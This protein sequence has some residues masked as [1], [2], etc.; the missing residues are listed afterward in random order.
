[1]KIAWSSDPSMLEILLFSHTW[2]KASLQDG[3]PKKYPGMYL[4]N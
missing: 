4:G 3:L 2:M 1:M